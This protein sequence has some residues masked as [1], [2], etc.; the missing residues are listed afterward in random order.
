MT[1]NQRPGVGWRPRCASAAWT[2]SE[3]TWA[4]GDTWPLV[5]RS[6]THT[7]AAGGI[8]GT[9]CS[10]GWRRSP[11][12]KLNRQ[13]LLARDYRASQADRSLGAAGWGR[14]RDPPPGGPGAVG[15]VTSVCEE[16]P[17]APWSAQQLHR[18]ASAPAWKRN[19]G[20]PRPPPPLTDQLKCQALLMA[21]PESHGPEWRPGPDADNKA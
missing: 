4:P 9:L 15:G 1:P 10:R 11:A 13:P 18:W 5:A 20:Q 16:L 2:R 7:L 19:A 6:H 3:G 21:N 8:S 17:W 12:V 14:G